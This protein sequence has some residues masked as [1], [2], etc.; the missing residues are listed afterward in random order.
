MSMFET[1]ANAGAWCYC[2]FHTTHASTV[3]AADTARAALG[4]GPPV[5]RYHWAAERLRSVVDSL[6]TRARNSP[7]KGVAIFVRSI[8]LVR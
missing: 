6:G 2:M 5:D 1:G 4:L 8:S 7:L 3:L